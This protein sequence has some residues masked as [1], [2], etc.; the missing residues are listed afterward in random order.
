MQRHA[1]ER[2]VDHTLE[3]WWRT[4]HKMDRALW[5]LVPVLFFFL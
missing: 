2:E 3:V 1:A 5:L 4:T